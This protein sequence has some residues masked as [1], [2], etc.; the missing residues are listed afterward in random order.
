MRARD[1]KAYRQRLREMAAR[2]GA[3]VGALEEEALGPTNEEAGAVVSDPFSRQGD[4][5]TREAEEDLALTLLG[6]EADVLGAV[7]AALTRIDRGTF[8]RCEDCGKPIAR[9]RLDAL[10]YARHCIACAR[11]PHGGAHP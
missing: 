2:L 5:G 6:A 1:L 9:A 3:G 8:G 4:D 7:I 10:P 11:G